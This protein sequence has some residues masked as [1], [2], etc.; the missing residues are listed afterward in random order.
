MRG[1]VVAGQETCKGEAMFIRIIATPPGEAP[2]EVRREWVG[3]ELPLAQGETGRR[4]GAAGG[5]LSGPRTF[6]AKLLAELVGRPA[7]EHGYV[8]DAPEALDVLAHKAPWAA[9]WWR[10]CAPHCWEPGHRFVFA[11]ELCEEVSGAAT[12][13]PA[14]PAHAR[15]EGFFATGSSGVTPNLTQQTSSERFAERPLRGLGGGRGFGVVVPAIRPL[16]RLAWIGA[17]IALLI[18]LADYLFV[19]SGIGPW[20]VALAGGACAGVSGWRLQRQPGTS[21]K[22]TPQVKTVKD[23]VVTLLIGVVFCGIGLCF[24]ALPLGASPVT[25]RMIFFQM[26]APFFIVM[27]VLPSAIALEYLINQ[28]SRPSPVGQEPGPPRTAGEPS[29]ASEPIVLAGLLTVRLIEVG[30]RVVE[31]R[32]AEAL[33]REDRWQ[34][35][36]RPRACAEVRFDRNP[37]R[38]PRLFVRSLPGTS[39]GHLP[40]AFQNPLPMQKVAAVELAPGPEG[41][42]PMQGTSGRPVCRLSLVLR[43]T[44]QPRLELAAH[45]DETWARETGGWL[46]RFL[47]V[48][49]EDRT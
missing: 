38:R 9:Q 18:V 39:F 21:E 7:L 6:L 25:P 34:W 2:E 5:A 17:G 29:S 11:A 45:A 40:E 26:I 19:H 16:K 33:T 31:L 44:S 35:R 36:P 46:A 27:G 12:R 48:P 41:A 4:A 30:Y 32:P 15:P 42:P 8:I 10:E 37:G 24:L 1:M 28:R 23:A 13:R 49:L 3:L 43:D 20:L 47:G 14:G 22:S